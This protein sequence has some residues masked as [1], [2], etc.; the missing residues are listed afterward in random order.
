MPSS[1]TVAEAWTT[2]RPAGQRDHAE[3][4]AC[5]DVEDRQLPVPRHRLD[6]WTSDRPHVY[7][8]AASATTS[9]SSSPTRWR[10]AVELH[11]RE[12]RQLQHAQAHQLL[13]F[14][15]PGRTDLL[16]YYERTLLN[17]YAGSRIRTR[18]TLQLLLHRPVAAR[19]KRQPLNYFPRHPLT[20][21]WTRY[22]RHRHR[23]NPA[24][25]RHTIYQPRTH[26]L[27]ATC[28]SVP[29]DGRGL[30]TSRPV[31]PTTRLRYVTCSSAPPTLRLAES[32]A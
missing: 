17:Q 7:V 15:Q 22:L 16:D 29:G 27:S 5:S 1:S 4:I 9:T 21:D 26:G 13:H 11:L 31:S 23:L 10:P 25:V 14:H 6:F 20:H 24:K 30:G 8:I 19:S 18:R 2:A 32:G 3:I 28:T 12:L